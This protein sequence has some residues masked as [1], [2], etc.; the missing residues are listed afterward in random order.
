MQI[1]I[2]L[3][4][5]DADPASQNLASATLLAWHI[6]LFIVFFHP[7]VSYFLG[8]E[9]MHSIVDLDPWGTTFN[10]SIRN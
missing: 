2:W 6:S 10:Q 3:L 7:L 1:R 5:F 9:I 8:T 4:N